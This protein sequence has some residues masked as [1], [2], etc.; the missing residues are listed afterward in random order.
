MSEKNMRNWITRSGVLDGYDPVA[1]EVLIPSGFPDV[2]FINGLIELK[3]LPE[4]PVREATPVRVDHFTR[5]Q[6]A[7][8]L[9]RWRAGRN[10]WLL[11][12]VEDIWMLFDG[13]TAARHVG[14]V[15]R[16]ALTHAAL[17]TW[18]SKPDDLAQRLTP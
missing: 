13:E 7:F 3:Y 1:V 14:F 15:P 6:R 17:F 9:K 16:A 8:L 10:A 4:W 12:Q 5:D 18:H 2:S 11:L